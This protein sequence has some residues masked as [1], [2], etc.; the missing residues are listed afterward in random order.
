MDRLTHEVLVVEEFVVEQWA[1]PIVA[2]LVLLVLGPEAE[3]VP[4]DRESRLGILDARDSEHRADELIVDVR[5]EASTE[6]LVVV[7]GE[8]GVEQSVGAGVEFRNRKESV[9]VKS[10]QQIGCRGEDTVS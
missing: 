6:E 9:I 7:D 8:V 1:V 2:L 5:V 10:I 3:S 4:I